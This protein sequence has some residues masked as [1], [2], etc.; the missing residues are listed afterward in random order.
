MLSTI[1]NWLKSRE[2]V[3]FLLLFLLTSLSF[4][5]GYLLAKQENIAPIIIEKA[6]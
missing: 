5:L 4:G 3:L 2:V 6:N 1:I